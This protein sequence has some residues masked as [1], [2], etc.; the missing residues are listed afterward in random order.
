M[1]SCS[2]SVYI[3][4]IQTIGNH[5]NFVGPLQKN[6]TGDSV[7]KNLNWTTHFKL[8]FQIPGERER[9]RERERLTQRR[10]SAPQLQRENIQDT[11]Y[12][13]QDIQDTL[14]YVQD[15]L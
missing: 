6:V 2:D 11:L 7:F 14:Y 1:I 9:E 8:C 3:E 10:Q 4:W 12:Y 5:G 15:T 13:V